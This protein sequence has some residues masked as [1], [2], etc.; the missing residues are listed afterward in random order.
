MLTILAVVL[1][2]LAR[3][4]G[5]GFHIWAGDR[6]L[7]RLREKRRHLPS[8]DLILRHPEPFLYGTVAADLISFKRFGGRRNSCHNWNMAERLA[9]FLTTPATRAFG[10]G[11]LCHL[12]ADVTSHNIFV[13]Y[14]RVAELTPAFMGHAFLESLA[15]AHMPER[16][17]E[18]L[19]EL[20]RHMRLAHYDA[21][22]DEAVGIKVLP[23]RGNRWIFRRLVLAACRPMWRRAHGFW[24]HGQRLVELD[25][26][27]LHILRN[28]VL[29]DIDSVISGRDYDILTMQD[30]SGFKALR[31]ARLLRRRILELYPSR[32]RALPEARRVARERFWN[33]QRPLFPPGLR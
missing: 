8:E 33:L 24:R 32:D 11:Y 6:T 25:L 19:E 26:T 18:K 20:R 17:W 16:S 30:P 31:D 5:P 9:P 7:E 4:W 28:Q 12:A 22:V 1:V 10:L 15:D 27:L 2:L 23:L 29:E 14:E 3:F 21:I 13:P